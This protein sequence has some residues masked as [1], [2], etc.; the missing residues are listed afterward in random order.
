MSRPEM[1]NAAPLIAQGAGPERLSRFD[2]RLSDKSPSPKRQDQDRV[3]NLLA[4]WRWYGELVYRLRVARLRYG[5][6]PISN[7]DII[8]Q[9]ANEIAA[10]KTAVAHMGGT[11]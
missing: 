4:L 2:G 7:A 1:V 10:F 6:D 5:A 8:D 9:L 3:G 11:A